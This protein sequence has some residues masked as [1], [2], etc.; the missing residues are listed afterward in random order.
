MSPLPKELLISILRADTKV[1]PRTEQARPSHLAP[2]ASTAKCEKAW[3]REMVNP[4]AKGRGSF[5]SLA[6]ASNSK[7]CSFK[8]HR[9]SSSHF[10]LQHMPTEAFKR[11]RLWCEQTRQRPALRELLSQKR[12]RQQSGNHTVDL[13][14]PT[15]PRAM[16]ASRPVQ[17]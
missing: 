14:F 13:E 1:L 7:L 17:W 3:V 6:A 11:T 4:S 12:A 9:G 8:C 10:F 16:G 15:V 5:T 2:N